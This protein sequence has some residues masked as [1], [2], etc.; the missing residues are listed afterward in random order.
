MNRLHAAQR[1]LMDKGDT[2]ITTMIANVNGLQAKMKDRPGVKRLEALLDQCQ[3]IGATQILI[4]EGHHK[5]RSS[6]AQ[7]RDTIEQKLKGRWAVHITPCRMFAG[8]SYSSTAV[9][10]KCEHQEQAQRIF[11]SG[12][13]SISGAP[14]PGTIEN[15]RLFE[16]DMPIPVTKQILKTLAG[17]F[18]TTRRRQ[19]QSRITGKTTTIADGCDHSA[20]LRA[21]V[22]AQGELEGRMTVALRPHE[23][24]DAHIDVVVYGVNQQSDGKRHLSALKLTHSIVRCREWAA[25][26]LPQCHFTIHGDT[27]TIASDSDLTMNGMPEG[28]QI[29]HI[30][31][32]NIDLHMG[33]PGI[34]SVS[35]QEQD[36]HAVLMGTE[37]DGA[38]HCSDITK[39]ISGTKHSTVE[40]A[41]CIGQRDEKGHNS[42]IPYSEERVAKEQTA[43]AESKADLESIPEHL[44]T[45]E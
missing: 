42:K 4:T 29:G 9:A 30:I 24:D 26:N 8:R 10:I 13:I 15:D 1:H 18:V 45:T 37:S 5:D 35:H 2:P 22:H 34:A 40:M 41:G 32:R 20:R 44:Q 21:F 28:P 39:K 19:L 25:R 7:V 27:N 36:I 43:T 12:Y 31:R 11:C 14:I 33:F 6:E 23:D 38:I 17:A 3:A 16:M